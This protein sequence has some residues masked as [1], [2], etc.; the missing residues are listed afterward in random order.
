MGIYTR[1]F[2]IVLSIFSLTERTSS[3]SFLAEQFD[4]K[5]NFHE[6]TI[7][8]HKI[9]QYL[10]QQWGKTDFSCIDEQKTILKTM[11]N[12]LCLGLC[13]VWAYAKRIDDIPQNTDTKP[14]DDSRFFKSACRLLA[15]WD[16]K[17][18]FSK[19]D[20]ALLDHFINLVIFFQ[21]Q[22]GETLSQS[23]GFDQDF[24]L[25]FDQDTQGRKVALTDDCT[26]FGTQEILYEQLQDLLKPQHLFFIQLISPDN[27]PIDHIVSCYQSFENGP[28]FY[29][30]P[31][32]KEGEY[33]T[34][35]L[36]ECIKKIWETTGGNY[37]FF[38]APSLRLIIVKSYTLSLHNQTNT[39]VNHEVKTPN[40]TNFFSAFNKINQDPTETHLGNTVQ[41]WFLWTIQEESFLLEA[42]KLSPENSA[43][44]EALILYCFNNKTCDW[45]Q[46]WSTM[47]TVAH[48]LYTHEKDMLNT[49][50]H[51]GSISQ[52]AVGAL[53]HCRTIS[54]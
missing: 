17:S 50:L 44:K 25:V 26:L 42:L 7:L 10:L 23:L 8:I 49:L 34:K 46:W 1:I 13:R 14:R 33:H 53:Y 16:E 22:N 15:L 36:R 24:E 38:G 6:Q 5:K 45:S 29:Y 12:G 47:P 41:N 9:E 32:S 39:P 4:N 54:S 31:N 18:H 3:H 20:T 37:N 30:D 40:L 48:Y 52:E 28:I 51:S 35:N 27:N 21:E 11:H 43:C 2:L 19:D